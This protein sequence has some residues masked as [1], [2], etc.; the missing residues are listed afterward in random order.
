MCP[1]DE[2]PKSVC[3][4]EKGTPHEEDSPCDFVASFRDD[5]GD[6]V[7]VSSGI[8]NSYFMSFRSKNGKGLHRI[9]SKALPERK[10][11]DQAQEDLNKYAKAK[12]WRPK[13]VQFAAV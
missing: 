7:F 6:R 9:K 8:G 11:F 13:D 5:N 12:G 3:P 1:N 2:L 4:G 10:T